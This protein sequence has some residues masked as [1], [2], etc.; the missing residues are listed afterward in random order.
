MNNT[1]PEG[2]NDTL[3]SINGMMF[4]NSSNGT[5][6]DRFV[7]TIYYEVN[8][9]KESQMVMGT[10]FLGMV[11]GMII[12][13]LCCVKHKADG[14]YRVPP[15]KSYEEVE[16]VQPNNFNNEHSRDARFEIGV[17]DEII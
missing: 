9:I 13:V 17:D 3:P 2:F 10:M 1:P 7:N 15:Q 14:Y 11:L 12:M 6:F 5:V 8:S 16:L 4:T